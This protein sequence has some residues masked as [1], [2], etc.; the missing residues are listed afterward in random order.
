VTQ[1]TV[2]A[3]DPQSLAAAIIAAET[4]VNAAGVGAAADISDGFVTSF[5]WDGNT[6]VLLADDIDGYVAGDDLLIT[7]IG[8]HNLTATNFDL[9]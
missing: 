4:A 9:A 3:A 2:D 5:Q 6:Y 7:L 8:Q 1:A